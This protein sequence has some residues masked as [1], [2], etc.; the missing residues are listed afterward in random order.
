MALMARKQLKVPEPEP[1]PTIV[2]SASGSCTPQP[3][4][5]PWRARFFDTM[6]PNAR[7]MSPALPLNLALLPPSSM[8][9]LPEPPPR[10]RRMKNPSCS[11]GWPPAYAGPADTSVASTSRAEPLAARRFQFDISPSDAKDPGVGDPMHGRDLAGEGRV[12]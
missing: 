12:P 3:H 1:R 6:P 10:E 9:A 11:R 5:V 4:I 8:L 2:M 7:F